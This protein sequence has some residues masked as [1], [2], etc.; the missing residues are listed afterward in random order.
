MN[1]RTL[2]VALAGGLF[3]MT[4]ASAQMSQRPTI[5]I[6]EALEGAKSGRIIL[7]DV[8]TP[9]EWADTGVPPGAILLDV[10]QPTFEA[11]LAGLRAENPG[12]TIAL[13]CRTANR[14][15]RAQEA[16][17][18]RGWRDL[19]DVRGGMLGDGRDTGW[20]D[21]GLPVVPPSR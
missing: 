8:R 14:S 18:A 2:I 15:R 10:S 12:K 5:S 3:V 13:F 20:L 11:R 4:D 17:M 9:Q 21:A 19:V 1:R 16:L 6:H 7:V